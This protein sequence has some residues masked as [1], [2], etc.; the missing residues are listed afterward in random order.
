MLD[1]KHAAMWSLQCRPLHISL[2]LLL[3]VTWLTCHTG[4]T[5]LLRLLVIQ[6]GTNDRTELPLSA[7][8][9]RAPSY[10]SALPSYHHHNQIQ[11]HISAAHFLLPG[12]WW[13]LHWQGQTRVWTWRWTTP[14]HSPHPEAGKS[15][16]PISI[17]EHFMTFSLSGAGWR[18]CTRIAPTRILLLHWELSTSIKQIPC[19]KIRFRT[20]S[21]QKSPYII[22][23]NL[24][25]GLMFMTL[26]FNGIFLGGA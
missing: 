24:N 4:S 17:R 26:M 12:A 1:T 2:W 8:S 9:R 13:P 19:D 6:A 10:W 18:G 5:D 15:P 21:P 7:Q 25:A 16:D 22:S 14:G 3:L 20:F 11:Y 23:S